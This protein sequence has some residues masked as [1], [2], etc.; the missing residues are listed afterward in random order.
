LLITDD[1]KLDL[2]FEFMFRE[3]PFSGYCRHP[4]WYGP[5]LTG[6]A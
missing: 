6:G 2:A 4:L 3:G 5:H 1:S